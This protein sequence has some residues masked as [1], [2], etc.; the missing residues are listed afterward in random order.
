MLPDVGGS[1]WESVGVG[2]RAGS[3]PG[4]FRACRACRTSRGTSGQSES[5]VCPGTEISAESR[6]GVRKK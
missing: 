2:G 6:G 4:E 1:R 3:G 5:H